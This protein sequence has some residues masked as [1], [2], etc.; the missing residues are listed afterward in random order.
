LYFLA[1]RFRWYAI[2]CRSSSDVVIKIWSS[3]YSIDFKLLFV[4]IY[5]FYNNVEFKLTKFLQLIGTIK[6]T[7]FYES[8]K[9][10]YFE[11]IQ[12]FSYAYIFIW[13]RKMDTDSLTETKN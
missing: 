10:N 13:V 4:I 11:N 7:I 2:V 12:H 5:Q 9:G 6:R 1:I 3:A 8:E